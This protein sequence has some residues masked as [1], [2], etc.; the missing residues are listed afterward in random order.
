MT[1]VNY[2]WPSAV[3]KLITTCEIQQKLSLGFIIYSCSLLLLD[4][5]MLLPYLLKSRVY[6]R[7]QQGLYIE[8]FA[9]MR[10][11]V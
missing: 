10:P 8:R 6:V 1:V 3:S 7:V 5:E 11:E 2:Y 4:S 9:Y